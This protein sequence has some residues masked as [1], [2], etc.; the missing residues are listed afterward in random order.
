[1]KQISLIALAVALLPGMAAASS[2]TGEGH[3]DAKIV[4]PVKIEEDQHL[5]FGTMTGETGT[6]TIDH[7]DGRTSTSQNL[8]SDSNI[9]KSGQI[10][11]TGPKGHA[12]TIGVPA[13]TSVQLDGGSATMP[14]T[15]LN[16]DSTS[17]TLDPS[18]GKM[19][20]KV[21][22]KLGVSDNQE[23]GDYHGTYTITVTY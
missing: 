5:N 23:E 12:I 22:G 2:K 15:D 19:T 20:V 9:P 7:A 14:V 17:G 11:I 6:V 16:L 18:T 21:G 13:T 4:T 3:A 8:V 1:M 10:T